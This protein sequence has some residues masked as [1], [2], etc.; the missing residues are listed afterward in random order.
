[1]KKNILALTTVILLLVGCSDNPSVVITKNVVVI[2]DESFFR[3]EQFNNYPLGN[4]TSNQVARM[5]VELV[6]INKTCYDSQQAIK[7]YL[8]QAKDKLGR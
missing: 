5:I 4:I 8:E 1:M 7:E 2:P 3:C 6:E